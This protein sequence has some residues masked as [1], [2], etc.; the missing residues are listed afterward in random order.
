VHP[1]RFRHRGRA[2]LL[3]AAGALLCAPPGARAAD[4]TDLKAAI[5]YNLLMFVEWP[6]DAMPPMGSALVLCVQADSRYAPALRVLAEQRVRGMQ[7]QVREAAPHDVATACNVLVLEDA[8]PA[9]LAALRRGGKSASVLVIADG[10][11]VS[12]EGVVV[13]LQRSEKKVLFDL[14]LKSARDARLQLSSKLMRLAR[15]LIE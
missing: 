10:T 14:N 3:W 7:V 1:F 12:R 13:S 4:E 6:A 11:D 5:V 2:A 9:Q 15:N 8:N